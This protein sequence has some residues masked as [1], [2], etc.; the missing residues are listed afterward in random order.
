MWPES[1]PT[2]GGL[3]APPEMQSDVR[4]LVLE[5][6]PLSHRWPALCS[7]LCFSS[8][9]IPSSADLEAIIASSRVTELRDSRPQ[10]PG[11]EINVFGKSLEI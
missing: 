9:L 4:E 1:I 2:C 8:Y 7:H 3:T 11:R 10:M 6:G 5:R